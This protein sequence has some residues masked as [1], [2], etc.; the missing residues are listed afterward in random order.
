MTFDA[1]PMRML[2]LGVDR[3]WLAQ[4]CDYSKST[5]ASALAPNGSN[6]TDKALRRIWEA[7][8]REEERQK[9]A[10]TS[11]AAP[12]FRVVIEPE[13]AR[14]DRWMQAVYAKPGRNFDEWAKQGLDQIADQE[15]GK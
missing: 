13:Q 2:Q 14:F 12:L 11:T 8:D 7:L 15:L 3:D 6:K 1:I 5:L 10:A 9:A 4:A